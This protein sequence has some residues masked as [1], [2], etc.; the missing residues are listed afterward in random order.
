MHQSPLEIKG[1]KKLN[2]NMINVHFLLR[3][4]KAHHHLRKVEMYLLDF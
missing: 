2:Q 3:I 4:T 1:E